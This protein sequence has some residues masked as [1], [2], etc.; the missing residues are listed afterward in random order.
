MAFN[1][2][3][4]VSEMFENAGTQENEP[5]QQNIGGQN[6]PSAENSQQK[7]INLITKPKIENRRKYS[8]TIKP[9]A[10]EKL[11]KLAKEHNYPSSSRFIEELIENI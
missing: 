9:S 3:N 7:S 11:D 6:S 5:K 4:P 10:R 8:F 2:N 1:E